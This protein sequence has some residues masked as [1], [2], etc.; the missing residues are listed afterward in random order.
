MTSFTRL[1]LPSRG[2]HLGGDCLFGHR[3]AGLRADLVQHAAKFGGGLA[4]AQFSR[5]QIAMEAESNNPL[6]RASFTSASGRSS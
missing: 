5:K 6:A 3:L 1:A 2:L 4:A